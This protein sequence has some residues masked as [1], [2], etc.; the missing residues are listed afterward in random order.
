MKTVKTVELSID[1]AR[2]MLVDWIHDTL[3]NDSNYLKELIATEG[4]GD[5]YGP[6][7]KMNPADVAD[8][9]GE[10]NL[11][12]GLA[13]EYNAEIVTVRLDSL[14]SAVVYDAIDPGCSPIVKPVMQEAVV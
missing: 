13:L 10:L 1:D 3:V 14:N 11:A 6:V 2:K 8:R 5:F 9:I 4:F 7:D 12:E